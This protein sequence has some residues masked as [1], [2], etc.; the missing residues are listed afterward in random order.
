MGEMDGFFRFFSFGSTV[1]SLLVEERSGCDGCSAL[2]VAICCG[3]WQLPRRRR[4]R[5]R[6]VVLSWLRL[7]RKHLVSIKLGLE[8][9]SRLCG[10]S[11]KGRG[12]LGRGF[13]IGL[14]ASTTA[15]GKLDGCT[16]HVHRTTQPNPTPIQRA[17]NQS[18]RRAIS[19]LSS[20]FFLSC[21]QSRRAGESGGS[22]IPTAFPSI[23]PFYTYTAH[24]HTHTHT[25]RGESK[26]PVFF[27]LLS[28]IYPVSVVIRS[29]T[30]ARCRCCCCCRSPRP[31]AAGRADFFCPPP[32][33]FSFLVIYDP[34]HFIQ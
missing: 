3:W 21:R 12:M 17:A 28:L 15:K 33:P 30:P 18:S 34:P 5:A 6:V 19:L 7:I 25:K 26:S 10:R 1:P 20:F 4:R 31:K 16:A 14:M 22:I 2:L 32:P 13:A 23:H 27:L 8:S 24:H 29:E 9:Y 11:K